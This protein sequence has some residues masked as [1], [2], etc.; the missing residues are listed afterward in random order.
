V[1]VFF[2]I[3]ALC[4]TGL[5][6]GMKASGQA[7][8]IMWTVGV[9]KGLPYLTSFLWSLLLAVANVRSS[10]AMGSAYLLVAYAPQIAILM[11]YVWIIR[12][13]KRGV[14]GE[15]SGAE[16]HLLSF[17]KSMSIAKTD[18]AGAI[19]KARNWRTT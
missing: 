12:A 13:A 15:L 2:G 11:F 3:V 17:R 1:N 10:A 19:L 7:G 14:L 6:F 9:V 18:A 8:A 4:W 16:S 5:W